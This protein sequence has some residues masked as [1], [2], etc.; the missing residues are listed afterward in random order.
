MTALMMPASLEHIEEA[1]EIGI[2]VGVGVVDRMAYACLCRKMDHRR[3]PVPCEQ[4]VH[5]GAVGE[6]G[7]FE[8]KTWRLSQDI[9]P[10]LFQDG[11]I[12]AVQVVEP[13][14]VAALGQQLA[15]G[16]K[17]DE[18]RSP[19]DQYWLIRHHIPKTAAVHRRRTGFGPL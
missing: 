15:G 5:R 8:T 14:D 11:V 16:V 12:I 3:E 17:A 9:Q 6:I 19:R 10:S 13:N 1:F 2:G 18:T 7:L 4:P